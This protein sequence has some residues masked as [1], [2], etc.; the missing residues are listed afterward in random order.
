[1]STDRELLEMAAKAAR[2]F[3]TKEDFAAR[4][5]EWKI[6]DDTDFDATSGTLQ[7]TYIWYGSN[8]EV[9]GTDRFDWDPLADDGDA[10]RLLRQVDYGLL[11]EDGVVKIMNKLGGCV[12]FADISGADEMSVIRRAITSAAAA[13]AWS[14]P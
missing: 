10:F 9:G 2:V 8:G 3:A 14:L 4:G 6:S 1:M 13:K 5:W 11:V 7:G 12:F